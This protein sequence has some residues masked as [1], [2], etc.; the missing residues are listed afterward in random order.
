M[1]LS[2]FLFLFLLM[3]PP[4]YLVYDAD[5]KQKDFDKLLK[6]A[7][8]ADIILFGEFHN[9]SMCHWLQLQLSKKLYE[10]KQKDLILAGEMF[11]TDDQ[12]VVD[13]YLASQIKPA[14]FEKEAK[15]WDNYATDYKPLIEFAK[16]KQLTFVASN[17]PRRYAAA[18][19]AGGLES[20]EKFSPEAKSYMCALPLE[21]DVNLP[22]YQNMLK[23]M[24]GHGSDNIIKAQALKDAT[25]ASRIINYWQ[26]G[27]TV[28][29]FNG[30]YHSDNYEGIVWYLKKQN[31]SLKILTISSL[32]LEDIE[33]FPEEKRQ[34]ADFVFAIPSDMTKTY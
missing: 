3:N 10:S 32:E 33:K 9:N 15:L 2:I 31:P 34:L 24:G 21:V 5:G 16:S 29:H 8:K 23:M 4:A 6:E 11:E 25:M 17:V 12:L 7:Q 18:V 26:K 14:N 22:A 19:A 20:L 13:E 28:L 30:A 27:K 1:K